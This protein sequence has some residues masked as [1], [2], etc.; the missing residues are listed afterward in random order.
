MCQ[1]KIPKFY[2][3]DMI[4]ET[5]DAYFENINFDIKTLKD[6]KKIYVLVSGGFDSTLLAEWISYHYPQKTYFVNCFSPYERS[7]VLD[8]Y[9][10]KENFILIKSGTYIE[11]PNG[12]R[13]SVK[14]EKEDT[15]NYGTILKESFLRL[16]EAFERKKLKIYDKKIF[17]CCYHIKHKHFYKAKFMKDE[18]S[19]VISGIK[20]GDGSQ[21]RIWLLQMSRG[22]NKRNQANGN[23]TFFHRHNT[24]FLYCYPFRDHTTRELGEEIKEI[25]WDKFPTLEHS[26]CQI[27]PVLVLFNLKR[28]GERYEKSMDYAKKLGILE[29][30]SDGS[31]N[32]KRLYLEEEEGD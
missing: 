14:P 16:P 28:E 15:L 19:V 24:G 21:R 20:R 32:I 27:C 22:T 29:E 6:Y 30:L 8:Y 23:P 9:S 10:K 17:K 11:L 1:T 4:M 26:G 12:E 31:Y 3:K 2:Q 7:D 13:V 25:L 18:G 5:F